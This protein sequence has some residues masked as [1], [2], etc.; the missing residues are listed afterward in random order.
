[1]ETPL[2]DLST[3]DETV[4]IRNNI[5]YVQAGTTEIN[6][7]RF[8][9]VANLEGMNWINTGWRNGD[10]SFTGTVN[11][12]GSLITGTDPGF[13]DGSQDDYTLALSSPCLDQGAVLPSTI[14]TEHDLLLEYVLHRTYRNKVAG[15]AA[16]DLGAFE[17][18]GP[19]GC[20]RLLP[21][22]T[23]LMTAPSCQP[24]PAGINDQYGDDLSVNEITATYGNQWISYK[25]N[26][27]AQAYDGP[28]DENDPLEL[29][30]GNWNYS[31]NAGTL[32][33][34]GTA[35]PTEDC[36]AYGWSGQ[37]CHVI[38]LTPSSGTDIWQ[39]VGHPFPYAVNWADVRVAVDG[40]SGWTVYTP[41]AAQTAGYVNKA[42]HTWN[43]SSYQTYDDSTPGSLGVL[44]PQE[45]IWLRIL[46]GSSGLGAGNFK[47]L[48]PAN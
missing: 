5:F 10:D 7:M 48:I 28:Q 17:Q 13:T 14:T 42:Y 33:L 32:S 11:Q 45:A 3:N 12:N 38:D 26:P 34:S 15:G 8:Y 31:V 22:N 47:L 4:D 43:G 44:Q 6:L 41:S 16:F 18:C 40:G 23:W 1:M 24:N 27:T 30:I 2:F 19:C 37:I 29:G 25:W 20:G 36:S 9:G 39:L 46:S 35:T 21:A